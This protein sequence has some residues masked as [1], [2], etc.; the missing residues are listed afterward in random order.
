[1]NAKFVLALVLVLQG[2][3]AFSNCLD[4]IFKVFSPNVQRNV[5]IYFKQHLTEIFLVQ[6]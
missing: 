5:Q 1:M 4:L 3:A 2:K 6:N